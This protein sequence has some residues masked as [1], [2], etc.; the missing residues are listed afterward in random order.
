MGRKL[1]TLI[2]RKTGHAFSIFGTVWKHAGVVSEDDFQAISA[3]VIL[4]YFYFYLFFFDIFSKQKKSALVIILNIKNL[5]FL[6]KD[7][8]HRPCALFFTATEPCISS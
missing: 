2:L 1:S 8:H 3:F 5:D 7:Y 6:T 4:F